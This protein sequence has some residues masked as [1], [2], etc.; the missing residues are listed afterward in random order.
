MELRV[1][2]S[3]LRFLLIQVFN[4]H[5]AKSVDGIAGSV[6]RVQT[7]LEHKR[8]KVTKSE[9]RAQK[10]RPVRALKVRTV[11]TTAGGSRPGRPVTEHGS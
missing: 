8:T 6:P 1:A 10:R 2:S 3:L 4:L 11:S 9:S 5:Q 7:N